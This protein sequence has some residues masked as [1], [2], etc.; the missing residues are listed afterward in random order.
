MTDRTLTVTSRTH[1]L[2]AFVT[3]VSGELDHHT[4]PRLREAIQ[5]AP[6][7]SGERMVLDLTPLVYCDS[8]GITVLIAAYHRAQ[9]TGAHLILVGPSPDLMR[10][11]RVVGIDQLFTFRA[12]V[13]E[14]L[15]S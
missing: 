7:T 2:G 9:S 12:S 5:E 6:F 1:P 10:V 13:E 14:A 3:R 4:A 8:T 11:F 15:D